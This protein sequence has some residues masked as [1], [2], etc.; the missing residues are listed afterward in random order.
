MPYVVFVLTS[1]AQYFQGS[2]MLS[3]ISGLHS[4]LGSNNILLYG[5]TTFWLIIFLNWKIFLKSVHPTGYIWSKAQKNTSP[6]EF[7]FKL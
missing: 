2:L 5:Q 6:K 3:C 4:F 1:F 7:F